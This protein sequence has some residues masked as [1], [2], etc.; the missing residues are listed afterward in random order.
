MKQIIKW[1]NR[2]VLFLTVLVCILM[3][4]FLVPRLFGIQPFVVLSGSMEP[5][6]PTGSVVFVDTKDRDVSEGDIITYDLAPDEEEPI[7]VTHRVKQVFDDRQIQTQGDH[8]EHADEYLEP[9]AIAG[10]AIFHIPYF[11]YVLDWLQNTG[12]AVVVFWILAANIFAMVLTGA[13]RDP[14]EL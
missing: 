14:E 1:F 4:G 2:L 11:G 13:V 12:Y 9:S 6:I 8:N 7:Y 10:T 5:Q 3:A